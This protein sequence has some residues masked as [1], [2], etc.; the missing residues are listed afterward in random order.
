[1]FEFAI[2][3][4]TAVQNLSKLFGFAIA[5]QTAGQNLSKP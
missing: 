4:Q 3:G 1:M 2:A 5:G